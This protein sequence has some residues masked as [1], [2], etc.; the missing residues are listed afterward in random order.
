MSQQQREQELR[1]LTVEDLHVRA[2]ELDIAGRSSML[3]DDLVA[4]IAQAEADV[5][6]EADPMSIAA[7]DTGDPG[8]AA[9]PVA[10]PL[11]PK[12]GSRRMVWG[13]L[14]LLIIAAIAVVAVLWAMD[15][16]SLTTASDVGATKGTS[17]TSYTLESARVESTLGDLAAQNGAFVVVAV[18]VTDE[19]PAQG[20]LGGP[21]IRLVGSDGTVYSPSAEASGALG[22]TALANMPLEP[23]TPVEGEVAFDVPEAAVADAELVAR[24]L[25]GG[26]DEVTFA[27]GLEQPPTS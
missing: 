25:S 4:A 12:R 14:G 6:A 27:L 13:I 26:A 11:T 18:T 16:G 8:D 5:P 3:K 10:A 23:G 17:S 7:G 15:D 1:E 20:L 19:N 2:R 21:A 22:D 9:E 24:D